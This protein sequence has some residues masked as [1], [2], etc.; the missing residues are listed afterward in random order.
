LVRSVAAST[1]TAALDARYIS[2]VKEERVEASKLL[3][4]PTEIP[5]V[6]KVQL[7]ADV[8]AA[9]YAAKICSYAQGM[10]IIK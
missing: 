9:L 1:I 4:G 3:S 10:N 2:G 6:D 5:H 7:V 8:R